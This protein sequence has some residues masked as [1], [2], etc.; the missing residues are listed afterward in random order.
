MTSDKKHQDV[1]YD[2]YTTGYSLFSYTVS[3]NYT[4]SYNNVN[5]SDFVKLVIPQ[6]KGKING[7]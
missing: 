2:K 7:S 3:K 5:K 4:V 1:V 6:Y